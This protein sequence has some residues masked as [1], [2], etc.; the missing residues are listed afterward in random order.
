MIKRHW[1]TA[2]TFTA[3]LLG[4]IAARADAVARVETVQN[5]AWIER[6]AVI[7]RLKSDMPLQSGDKLRTGADAR[8]V[9]RFTDGSTVKVGEYAKVGLDTL[10]APPKKEGWITGTLNVLKGAFRFTSP[11]SGK[12]EMTIQVKTITMGIRG[13]DVWG[14]AWFDKDMACLL[15]GRVEVS[16]GG[17]TAILDEPREGFVVPVGK[18]PLPV[19]LIPEEKIKKWIKKV[20]LIDLP[21][22]KRK[23]K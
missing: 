21:V 23:P 13:T 3:G 19:S 16:A 17:V 10:Q 6:Q 5:Q 9:I 12:R 8:V 18:A 20:E 22:S 2:V 7:Y 15:E 14:Q 4:G 1:L 11:K